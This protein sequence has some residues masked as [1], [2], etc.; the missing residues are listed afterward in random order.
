[1]N[2][3]SEDVSVSADELRR[4]IAES[5]ETPRLVGPFLVIAE[6]IDENGENNLLSWWDGGS[7]WS[8][9]GMANWIGERMKREI[10]MDP[11]D[12]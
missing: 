1:M 6:V 2:E 3:P 9:L 12:E 8:R 10:V 11:D 5:Y 4:V 7:Q